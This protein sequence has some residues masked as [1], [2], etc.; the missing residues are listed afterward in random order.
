MK[1]ITVLNVIVKVF[2]TICIFLFI[3]EKEDYW[4]Y[5]LLQSAG[6]IGAGIIGQYLLIKKYRVKFIWLKFR[7]ISKTISSNFPIFVNQF[8]P[9]LYN[10]TSTF[11]LGILTTTSNV[12]IYYAIK[13]IIDLAITLIGI[14]SRVFFPFLNRRKGAFIKYKKLMLITGIAL[15]ALSIVFHQV[16]FWYLNI[17]YPNAFWVLF[18][19]ALGIVGYTVY[20]IFGINY[21]I[22]RR[23]DKLVM[24]N[25]IYVSIIGLILAYPLI[26]FYGI[27][28]AAINLS[29]ARLLMGG[30]LVI[31]YL[32]NSIN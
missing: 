22:V 31:K 3:K 2:F 16:I 14:L 11:L 13:K 27:L 12:G 30:G 10:N 32:K 20:D 21:F 17:D 6:F 24:I 23:Q 9:T 5:P 1:Y 7:T 29:L 4:I 26:H 8:F 25:T 28:G 18:I 19:L 15:A